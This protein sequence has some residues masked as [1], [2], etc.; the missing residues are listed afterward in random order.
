LQEFTPE[1]F[2]VPASAATDTPESPD[3]NNRAAAAANA[4]LDTLLICMF[5]PQIVIDDRSEIAALRQLDRGSAKIITQPSRRRFDYICGVAASE[6][7]ADSYAARPSGQREE[8]PV[9][10]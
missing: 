10:D 9:I 2:T 8:L 4:A 7:E 5:D 3:V 6:P 1:H